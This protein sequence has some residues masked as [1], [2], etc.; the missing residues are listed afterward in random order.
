M[1]DF[2]HMNNFCFAEEIVEC[3]LIGCVD[4]WMN[5]W[6]DAWVSGWMNNYMHGWIS[7]WRHG[8]MDDGWIDECGLPC[9]IY[10]V[11]EWL[12]CPEKLVVKFN[13]YFVLIFTYL[14]GKRQIYNKES[15][16]GFKTLFPKNGKSQP[17]SVL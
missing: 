1:Y 15:C 12:S 9:W 2:R 8:W 13:K 10:D 5:G 11:V 3:W 6:R 7:D 17:F 16:T 14:E 4:D